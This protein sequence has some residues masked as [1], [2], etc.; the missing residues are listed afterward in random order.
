MK[1]ML[2]RSTFTVALAGFLLAASDIAAVDTKQ[3][4]ITQLK[5]TA[6]SFFQALNH[7]PHCITRSEVCSPEDKR[8][9]ISSAKKFILL[10]GSV[11]ASLAVKR[12]WE[13]REVPKQQE[14]PSIET[15]A[16]VV[17]PPQEESTETQPASSPGAP[18]IYG[19]WPMKPPV[20]TKSS[21]LEN[22]LLRQYGSTPPSQSPWWNQP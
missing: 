8:I 13:K 4:K 15:A 2:K 17:T 22:I 10:L 3:D 14:E 20:S 1:T 21:P 9:L 11:I 16:Q 7:A 12:W 19:V 18:G 6:T 5:S